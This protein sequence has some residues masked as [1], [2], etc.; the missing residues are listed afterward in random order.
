MKYITTYVEPA[1]RTRKPTTW[2]P[3]LLRFNILV[4]FIDHTHCRYRLAQAM[5]P[6]VTSVYHEKRSISGS[7]YV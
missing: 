1:L 5:V 6:K 2:I 7:H 4:G 3:E